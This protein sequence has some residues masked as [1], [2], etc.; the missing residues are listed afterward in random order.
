MN[1]DDRQLSKIVH[2]AVKETIRVHGPINNDLISSAV[3]RIV[4]QLLGYIKQIS[5]KDLQDEGIKLEFERLKQ[6]I[7]KKEVINLS[8]R[9]S[10]K[11]FL[12]KRIKEHGP[13]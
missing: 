6:V 5:T 1:L 2:G 9:K 3:R 4:G 12:E 13:Q 8:L 7:A 10:I 11:W